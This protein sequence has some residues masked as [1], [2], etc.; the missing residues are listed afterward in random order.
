MY[1]GELTFRDRWDEYQK[2]DI[3]ALGISDD[4]VA[5]LADFAEKYDLPIR[6]L[7]E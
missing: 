6:L 3:A 7:S 2:R 1:D 4:S 5:D